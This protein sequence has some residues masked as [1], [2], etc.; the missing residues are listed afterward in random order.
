M[1]KLVLGLA[2]VGCLS[3][4]SLLPV[5]DS[6]RVIEERIASVE[7]TIGSLPVEVRDDI[8][9]EVEGIKKDFSAI[10][11]Y[12]LYGIGGLLLVALRFVGP[13]VGGPLGAVL[14]AIGSVAGHRRAAN[15]K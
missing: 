13:I 2:L 10:K 14:A 7:A 15:D 12:G 6:Q 1:K 9:I 5:L 8:R 4:C 3:G 11:E